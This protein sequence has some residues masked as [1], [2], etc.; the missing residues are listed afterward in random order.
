[1]RVQIYFKVELNKPIDVVHNIKLD[2][3]FSGRQ[4]LGNETIID[5]FLYETENN[6][7]HDYCSV[8]ESK[9]WGDHSYSLPPSHEGLPKLKKENIEQDE[10]NKLIY[11]L[12]SYFNGNNKINKTPNLIQLN[13]KDIKFNN[14]KILVFGKKLEGCMLSKFIQNSR[15]ISN[16]PEVNSFNLVLPQNRFKNM[17]EA[18][19][20]VFKKMP[21]YS[22]LA[23]NLNY[24]RFYPF[25][26]SS[27]KEFVSW[28]VGKRRSS[29]W[30]RARA[31]KKILMSAK[32][33]GIENW[34]T[35]AI[36]MYGRSHDYT[37]YISYGLFN[38]QSEE[39]KLILTCYSDSDSTT[40]EKTRVE[41][42]EINV[43]I[44]SDSGK[45]LSY[46]FSLKKNFRNS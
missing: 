34:N 10:S 37:P 14:T 28:N 9:V 1:M 19:N 12:E 38:R 17:G 5:V 31:I 21:L 16:K 26:A 32:I 11:G 18:L 8:E 35:K 40:I 41:E 2:K 43:N 4:T 13:R 20:Y 36:L 22:D 24:K 45:L 7:E 15:V 44:E 33:H 46:R 29:E 39:K 42:P 27:L 3:T 30:S 25:T 6:I 23:N